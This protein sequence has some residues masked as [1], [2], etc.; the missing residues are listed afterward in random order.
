MNDF[1]MALIFLAFKSAVLWSGEMS[2]NVENPVMT[3]LIKKRINTELFI[4]EV[5]ALQI[6][7]TRII[8]ATNRWN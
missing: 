5:A 6:Q 3:F 1:Q 7:E 8:N 2:A 4:D